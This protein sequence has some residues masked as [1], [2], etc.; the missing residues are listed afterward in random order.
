MAT[1]HATGRGTM[2]TTAPAARAGYAICGTARS[3]SSWFAG[4]LDSTGA[5]GHPADAFNTLYQRRV[6]GAHY[7]ADRAEQIRL[8]LTEGATENGIYGVK[9]FPIQLFRMGQQIGWTRHLP[10]LR[11][12]HWR[13]R[14]LLGQ[15]LSRHRALQTLQWRSTLEPLG[16]AVYDGRAIMEALT[17]AAVQDA[18]WEVFLARNGIAPLRLVYEDVMTDLQGAIDGVSTLMGLDHR[19]RAD[20]SRIGLEIQRDDETEAWRA[21][22][23]GEHGNPDA[24]DEL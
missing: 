17:W 2:D 19:P 22:F 23:I 24:M 7:P 15:A 11:F 18:R 12:I 14:D 3:G 6:L 21:R 20:S 9:V 16:D 8:V 13:R 5:L 4:A 10:N 1:E